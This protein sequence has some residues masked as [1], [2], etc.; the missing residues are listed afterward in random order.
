MGHPPDCYSE[1][2]GAD[3]LYRLCSWYNLTGDS[4]R[5]GVKGICCALQARSPLSPSLWLPFAKSAST[6]FRSQWWPE[7][8]NHNE[9]EPHR[10]TAPLSAFYEG[11]EIKWVSQAQPRGPK[12]GDCCPASSKMSL[13]TAPLPHRHKWKYKRLGR[14][15]EPS[16]HRA[17]LCSP[18]FGE[19]LR[20]QSG[21]AR[22]LCLRRRGIFLLRWS[23]FIWGY[24]CGAASVSTVIFNYSVVTQVVV[25]GFACGIVQA[26]HLPW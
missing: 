7:P 9:K 18:V 25:S 11:T 5:W 6:G 15:L 17:P 1:H 23:L 16:A 19:G 4:L 24:C 2:G 10:D 21:E 20:L 26:Q 8:R 3:L 13:L 14:D 22:P 12:S